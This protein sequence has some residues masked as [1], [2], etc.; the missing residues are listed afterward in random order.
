VVCTVED[1]GPGIPAE[2]RAGGFGLQ[3]V[4]RRLE[5]RYPERSRFTIESSPMG[6]R[7]IVELPRE[8]VPAGGSA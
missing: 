8:H 3:S 1:N 4:R 6:T 7:S 5:L 2:L